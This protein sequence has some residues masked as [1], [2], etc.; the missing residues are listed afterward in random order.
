M[1]EIQAILLGIVQGLT[2]FLPVSSSGHL[3]IGKELFGVETSDLSF[4]IIVHAATVCSTLIAL[5][6]EIADILCGFF[7]F[8][9]NPQMHYVLKI[10][11][12][13]IPIFIVGVFFKEY[14]EQIFGSGLLIVGIMLCITAL[15]LVLSEYLSKRQAA[16]G[17]IGH[18]VS[19]KDAFIIGLAQACA[20]LPGLSRSGSTIATGLMLGVDKEQVAKFSFLMVIVPVLGEAILEVFSGGFS[21]ADSGMSA[22]VLI[23]GFLSAFVSG[24]FACRWMIAIVKKARLYYFSIY[25]AVVGIVSVISSLV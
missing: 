24:F 17:R 1:N 15:L 23:L 12:S 20:V 10:A 6:K 5:R 13:M 22:S 16:S 7:K 9:N 25:C 3:T 11:V 2:E 21:M 4:E 19:Y 18:E 8:R 14:V